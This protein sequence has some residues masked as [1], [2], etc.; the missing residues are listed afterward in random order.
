MKDSSFIYMNESAFESQWLKH[1]DS[2][3]QIYNKY[4]K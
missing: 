1:N 3:E 4:P 2:V